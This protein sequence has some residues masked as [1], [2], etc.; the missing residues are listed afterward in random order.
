MLAVKSRTLAD[1]REL[2]SA[3]QLQLA[4][5]RRE[6]AA[7]RHALMEQQEQLRAQLAERAVRH[8]A[9]SKASAVEVSEVVPVAATRSA[10][11]VE[12]TSHA[13]IAAKLEARLRHVSR[14][15]VGRAGCATSHAR[16]K[17]TVCGDRP[18]FAHAR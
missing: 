16:S 6:A 3:L 10:I 14:Q 1:A 13:E 11:N 17:H 15:E 18:S 7:E 2:A 4:E 5:A 12:D 9:E 8:A